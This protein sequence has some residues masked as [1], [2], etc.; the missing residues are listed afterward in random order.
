M[1]VSNGMSGLMALM[2]ELEHA[3]QFPGMY[4]RPRRIFDVP[5]KFMSQV[6]WCEEWVVEENRNK[7]RPDSRSSSRGR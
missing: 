4:I 2:E 5:G 3:P 1:D 6:L 7:G